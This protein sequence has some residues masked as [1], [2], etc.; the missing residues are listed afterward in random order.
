MKKSKIFK[1]VK[2]HIPKETDSNIAVCG[3]PIAGQMVSAYCR[4]AVSCRTC[5]KSKEFKALPI[6]LKNKD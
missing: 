4:D 6:P 3:A 1:G 2:V 5:R